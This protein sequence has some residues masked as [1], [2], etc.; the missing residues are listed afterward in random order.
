MGN[1][2]LARG[3][4]LLALGALGLLIS[5]ACGGRESQGS[6]GGASGVGGGALGVG[7]NGADGGS[8]VSGSAGLGGAPGVGGAIA[9]GGMAVGGTMGGAAVVVCGSDGGTSNPSGVGGM[10]PFSR[11]GTSYGGGGNAG[12]AIAM[13]SPY[14]GVYQCKG[15]G[16][17]ICY[18][19]FTGCYPLTVIGGF[20]HFEIYGLHVSEC[21]GYWTGPDFACRTDIIRG[22]NCPS[23]VTV[24]AVSANHLTFTSTLEASTIVATGDCTR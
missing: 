4:Q 11:G 19:P 18:D 16:S 21:F 23:N 22:R 12:G 14:D 15:T 17:G 20:I 24:H 2:V 7:G 1:G 5:S 6:T 3:Q 13:T 10:D 9:E 8:A